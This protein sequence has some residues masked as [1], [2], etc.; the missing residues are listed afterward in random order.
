MKKFGIL[1]S[2]S[3]M[4]IIIYFFIKEQFKGIV[5]SHNEN[6]I[7]SSAYFM[8]AIALFIFARINYLE[9]KK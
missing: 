4:G 3:G 9:K 1:S 2:I 6:M 7:L 5:L 8:I